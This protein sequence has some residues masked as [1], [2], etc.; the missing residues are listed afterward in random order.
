MRR[1]VG[2]FVFGLVLVF[3][4]TV[5]QAATTPPIDG[6]A[7]GIELCPQFICGLAIFAGS[8][9]GQIGSNPNANAIVATALNHGELPT[10]IGD[11]TPIYPGGVWQLKTLL[12]R[13][14]GVVTGGCIVYI[15]D[16]RFFVK[17]GMHL[18]S[19]GSGDLTFEGI[20]DHNPLIPTFAGTLQ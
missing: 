9:H 4:S 11:L 16:N 2:I 10:T 19:G 7:A 12:R 20:L 1:A 6:Q 13:F 14:S 18:T 15:G 8:F 17:I 3:G 5:A